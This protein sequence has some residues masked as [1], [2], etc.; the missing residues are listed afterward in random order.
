MWK[1]VFCMNDPVNSSGGHC[2]AG[3]VR[4]FYGR[5]FL[6]PTNKLIV[7]RFPKNEVRRFAPKTKP[8]F[9]GFGLGPPKHGEFAAHDWPSLV[10]RQLPVFRLP[11]QGIQAALGSRSKLSA[12][13]SSK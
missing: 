2:N 13:L 7:R 12:V 3:L 4:I 11:I 9:C 6:L 1:A 5:S 8:A 10:L